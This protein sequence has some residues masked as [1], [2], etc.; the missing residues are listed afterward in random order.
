MSSFGLKLVVKHIHIERVCNL[1]LIFFRLRLQSSEQTSTLVSRAARVSSRD[2]LYETQDL[3][4]HQVQLNTETLRQYTLRLCNVWRDVIE[5]NVFIYLCP[6][7]LLQL[8]KW[9]VFSGG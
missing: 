1:S 8:V 4:K 3:Y 9:N 2:V 5:R 7:D 6:H